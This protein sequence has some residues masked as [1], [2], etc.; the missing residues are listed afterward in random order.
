MELTDHKFQD[1]I[2]TS[3]EN[4]RKTLDILLLSNPIVPKKELV[5]LKLKHID[6]LKE[7]K[8]QDLI[9]IVKI[10]SILLGIKKKDVYLHKISDIAPYIV[11]VRNALDN[12][13][14]AESN[15]IGDSDNLKWDMVRGSERMSPL[16]IYNTLIP[17]AE[18]FS[19]TI[20]TI[21]NMP[22][23]DIYAICMYN[24]IKSELHKEMSNIKTDR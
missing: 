6:K 10:I 21:Y 14:N 20:D 11:Y 2:K 8:G 19:T 5:D 3:F 1:F 23:S 18:Q 7:T 4:Q 9:F 13:I 17:L 15:L 12:I 16:G 22:Y 24:K